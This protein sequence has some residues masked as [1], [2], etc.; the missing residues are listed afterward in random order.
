MT[1]QGEKLN[2]NAVATEVSDIPP[3]I[4]GAGIVLQSLFC[5]KTRVSLDC[6]Q[7]DVILW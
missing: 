7:G 3:G 1:G 5:L 2:C 4:S 6:P